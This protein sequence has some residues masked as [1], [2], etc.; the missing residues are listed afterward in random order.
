MDPVY[1]DIHI[2]TSS[3]PNNL[4]PNYDI[5][6]L[7]A[8]VK[9]CAQGQ[10]AL[11]S[12]TDHNTMNKAAYLRAM[13]LSD[14]HIH[15]ILG[16]ELH[17][18]YDVNTEAYHC[19]MLFKNEVSE[20]SIDD[21][22]KILD[23]LYPNK[24]VNK[25]NPT[26][27]TLEMI[28]NAFDNYDFILLPHGGQSHATFN[29]AIPENRRFDTMLERSVYYNQFDGFTARSESGR[30]ETDRYFQ[31]LGIRDF[32][33]LVTCSDNYDPSRYPEAKES[34]AEPL[35]PTWMLS[36]PSFEGLRL[37]L[38]ERSRLV[39]SNQKPT[40]FSE[41]I[42]SANCRNTHLDIDVKF[43]M[44]LNVII[45]GSSS[46]KTLLVESIYRKLS[47]KGMEGCCYEKF[48][49]D[50]LNV[51]NPSEMEPHYLSQ[52][53]IVDVVNDATSS[54]ISDID[55]IKSLFPDS[56]Q[57]DRQIEESLTKLRNDINELISTVK[58]IE[59]L[60]NEFGKIPQIGRLVVMNQV[61]QNIID[62]ML[63][64]E[65]IRNPIRYEKL[66]K[67]R[68]ID[69]LREIKNFLNRNPLVPE[70]DVIIDE[71][72]SVL[73]EA[74]K[75]SEIDDLVY[76]KIKNAHDSY[77]SLLRSENQE[78]QS[79]SQSFQ[80]VIENISQYVY[81][82]KKFKECL[83]NIATNDVKFETKVVQSAGHSLYVKNKY[84]IN[85]N[86][87]LETFN[88]LLKSGSNIDRF[89]N[90]QPQ[91]LYEA[92]YRKRAPN[93]VDYADFV[94][95]VYN[96]FKDRNTTEFIIITQEGKDFNDLSAGWRTSVLLD[97]I[98]G[99]D[100]DFAPIIIDQPEDNLATKYINEGLVSAIKKVKSKK[101]IIL[102][103]HNATIPM[104]GDAQQ[105]IYCE[106]K[107][108]V[109]TIRSAPLEGEINGTPVLDLIASITDG[110]KSSI[111]KRVKK[112]NLKKF[113]E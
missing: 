81:L 51:L 23:S 27:P 7:F 20:Q 33:N 93:V 25:T 43:G 60:E 110:G 64:Q 78:D 70:H 45:G 82:E 3:N 113:T 94:N 71:L 76:Q 44:G 68:D 107:D 88:T 35:I 9:S 77:A 103:S 2:H 13:A 57:I 29:N 84:K 65:S 101:Q 63:P 72:I 49:V 58:D 111:K 18:H 1:V 73:N 80:K 55:V 53:F 48:G 36:E 108:S 17:V 98:L 106:N 104:M 32:V 14:E 87:V 62:S 11:I 16:V 5:E 42:E 19:H 95:R 56:R 66:K 4:N 38:S 6:T 85:K 86:I 31:R 67:D 21:I 52:N 89:E 50:E 59:R 41:I 99:Y 75:Y 24:V 46:G 22:N 15:L 100:H 91:K 79:K 83:N 47:K 28:I 12:F 34:G 54:K 69:T 92:N 74:F 30:E 97:L 39:Y 90:I 10:R 102:V 96:G 8:K 112:Y 61:K 109:I 105:V 40:L 37:S 26:I